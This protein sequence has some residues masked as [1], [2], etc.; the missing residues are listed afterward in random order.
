MI[1]LQHTEPQNWMMKVVCFVTFEDSYNILHNDLW[2]T[3]PCLSKWSKCCTVWKCYEHCP[4]WSIQ[5][6]QG[7]K[8]TWLNVLTR[9]LSTQTARLL[10]CLLFFPNKFIRY[11]EQEHNTFPWTVI[12][13]YMIGLQYKLP[14]I[15]KWETLLICKLYML[16]M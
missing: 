3:F 10:L 12:H 9:M 8:I 14:V 11:G 1:F 7:P 2:Q 5:Y 6:F 16:I 4:F 15:L 13:G